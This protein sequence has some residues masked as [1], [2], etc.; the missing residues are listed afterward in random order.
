MEAVMKRLTFA[1]IQALVILAF[2]GCRKQAA[3]I[4]MPPSPK[5][6]TNRDSVIAHPPRGMRFIKGGTFRMGG[7]NGPYDSLAEAKHRADS[8]V[9]VGISAQLPS[10]LVTVGDFFMDT[11]EVTEREWSALLGKPPHESYGKDLPVERA[12]WYQAIL[13][14]NA[15]SRRDG[16]HPVYAYSGI[17]IKETLLSK[18]EAI[19]DTILTGLIIDMSANGYRLPTEAEFEYAARAGGESDPPGV[20]DTLRH[21]AGYGRPNPWG[22]YDLLDNVNEWANDGYD[23]NYYA[24]AIDENPYGRDDT[25]RAGMSSMEPGAPDPGVFAAQ[26]DFIVVRGPKWEFSNAKT[27]FSRT[28]QYKTPT[29]Y[30]ALRTVLQVR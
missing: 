18:T 8:G 14:A 28:R 23:E 16:L 7:L 27:R 5:W 22:I 30:A 24:N 6:K 12:T 9:F 20:L 29:E 21:P 15:K 19:K 3:V 2:C 26:S 17:E 25:R 11:A 4:P 10:H 13:Y 1:F